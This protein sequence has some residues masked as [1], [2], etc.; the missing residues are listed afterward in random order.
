LRRRPAQ[1]AAA[2]QVLVPGRQNLS[3]VFA[4]AL[5]HDPLA[6]IERALPAPGP[7]HDA[8]AAEAAGGGGPAEP[9]EAA[10]APA[11]GPAGDRAPAG[12]IAVG[13]TMRA[14]QTRHRAP[15]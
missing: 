5:P 2:A 12:L 1:A 4:W 3:L 15:G 14:T 11:D 7:A 13:R 6:A 8:E 9:D 10:P